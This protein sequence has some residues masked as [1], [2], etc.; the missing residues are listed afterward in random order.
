MDSASYIAATG[1]KASFR[2]LEIAT[3][4]LANC[5]SPGFKADRPFYRILLDEYGK[6]SGS[7]LAGTIVDFKPGGF[8]TTGN[9][10]DVAINGD[11]F[12]SIRTP[13]GIRYTRNGSFSISPSGELVTHDG[14]QVLN[15]SGG[16]IT[17]IR[18]TQTPNELTI[19]RTG[20]VVVD[21]N[22][23]GTIGVAAFST[24]ESLIKEGDLN[25]RTADPPQMV[26]NPNIEQGILEQSNVNAINAM[27]ELIRI[28]RTFELNQKAVMTTM[29]NLN[30]RAVSDITAQS[31]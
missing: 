16:A 3:N 22:I 25:F 13:N 9:P 26:A 5:N 21:D 19:S 14:Y 28:N 18:G 8:K 23:V 15:S 7:V 10:L 31:Y 17:I 11:G 24:P 30:R 6:M 27:L 1:M 20:E 12:F 4:N 2:S 29:N